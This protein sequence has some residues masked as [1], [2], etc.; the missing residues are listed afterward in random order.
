MPE[1]AQTE[2][3]ELR[4]S[5]REAA[6]WAAFSGVRFIG[7]ARV[8]RLRSRFLAL[9]EAWTA[10]LESMRLVLEPRALSELAAARRTIEPERRMEELR[11]RGIRIVHAEH[12]EYPQLLAEA[13]GRPTVL[14]VRGCLT[15]DDA[16]CV[17]IVGTRRSTLYGRNMTERIARDLAASAV[18]VVS[19]LARGIDA[20]AH[21]TALESG[22]RTV[23]VLGSGVDVIYPAEHRRLAER[24]LEHG[25]VIS[26]QPPGARPEAPNFP[27]RNRIISGMS[28]GVVVIEAPARS[29]ALITASFA[30][31]QGRE[32]F[33][34]PGNV[35]NATS[36]GTNQLLRDGARIVRDG[37]DILA[38]LN[39]GSG[40]P[41]QLTLQLPASP[42]EAR[43]FQCLGGEPLHLD[44]IAEAARLPGPKVAETLLMME[45]KGTARN[46]GAQYYVRR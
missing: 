17:G 33:V 42:E 36:E 5:D 11:Q 31:D 38:D 39:I 37:A 29:G 7:P 8:A 9:S 2:I 23:A 4:D 27:A 13:S 40:S 28:L 41:A 15:S 25:A 34:V 12:P 20:V 19:G 30:A 32:V 6:Y 46:C 14:Y 1:C 22:G 10:P 45:L 35:G 16:Q 21:Q 24:I 3:Q 43:V 44:E 26:E 18:T